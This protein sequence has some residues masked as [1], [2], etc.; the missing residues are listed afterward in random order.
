[1]EQ[2]FF[3]QHS[4]FK[5]LGLS[6]FR[7][8]FFALKKLWNKIFFWNFSKIWIFVNKNPQNL[9]PK[10]WEKPKVA[11]AEAFG[12]SLRPNLRFSS[13]SVAHYFRHYPN[14]IE[15][16]GP[17][18]LIQRANYN[19]KRPILLHLVEFCGGI[20]RLRWI[21]LGIL[22]VASF[23][24]DRQTNPKDWWFLLMTSCIFPPWR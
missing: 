3:L 6:T 11:S 2:R 15:Y 16:G 24:F 4:A 8:R 10:I 23:R 17:K 5:V 21:V 1:M 9:R 19:F 20:W 14:R 12:R 22:G 18:C 13:A 7:K